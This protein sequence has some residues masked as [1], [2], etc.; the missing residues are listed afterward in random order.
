MSASRFADAVLGG[1][2]AAARR[3]PA[4]TRANAALLILS[5]LLPLYAAELFFATLADPVRRTARAAGVPYDSRSRLEVVRDLRAAGQDAVPWVGPSMIVS[6]TPEGALAASDGSLLFPLGGIANRLTVH[7]NESGEYSVYRSDRHGFNNP[8]GVWSVDRL[9]VAAV[10][11]SFTQ[12][13]CVPPDSSAIGRLRRWWPATLN[14][15]VEG[16]GPHVALA[17]LEEY[18]R[19]LR[20]RVV[21]WLY[22]EGNDLQDLERYGESEILRR[23]LRPGYRQGL[24]TRQAEI[25]SGLTAWLDEQKHGQSLRRWDAF[26]RLFHLRRALGLNARQGGRRADYELLSKIYRRADSTVQ[27]WGGQLVFVYVPDWA[28]YFAPGSRRETSRDSVLSIVRASGMPVID[29][30]SAFSAVADPAPLFAQGAIQKAHFSAAGYRL[31]AEAIA[32]R[33]WALE[34]RGDL[35]ESET[36]QKA[37]TPGWHRIGLRPGNSGSR[38][39][40]RCT[41]PMR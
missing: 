25:D 13:S 35:P 18:A 6:G 21:L 9:D 22:Y 19:P 32:E 33:L 4:G 17:A 24:A 2:L 5:T 7:C 8:P 11:D 36:R 30:D 20:P 26:F 28:R 12:G 15:G 14:L 34:C 3:L 29:L 16:T 41:A 23:Y 10:G 1:A 38:G 37:A 31:A 27:S 39:L 40:P